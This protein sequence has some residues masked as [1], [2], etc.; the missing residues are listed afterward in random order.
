MKLVII[1]VSMLFVAGCSNVGTKL[2]RVEANET[3]IADLQR[4][5]TA[6]EEAI[7]ELQTRQ[8]DTGCPAECNVKIDRMFEKSQYK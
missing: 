8:E 7:L 5:T 4:V 3:S 1:A 2:E 6:Q